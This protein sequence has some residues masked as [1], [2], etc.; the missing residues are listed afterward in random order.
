M[1]Y[2]SPEWQGWVLQE[3]E[4]IKHIKFAYVWRHV[5]LEASLLTELTYCRYDQG[6]QSFDTANVRTLDC[7]LDLAESLRMELM[8]GVFQ[9]SI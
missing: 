2:G 6:I 1:T 9:W 3:E 5:K 7:L 4:A 8:L